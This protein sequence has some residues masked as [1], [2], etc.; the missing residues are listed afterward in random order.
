LTRER[1]ADPRRGAPYPPCTGGWGGAYP[2]KQITK[3][4]NPRSG[5]RDNEP[6]CPARRH[7]PAAEAPL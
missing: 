3:S 5:E 6:P 7:N 4:V 1:T 2:N